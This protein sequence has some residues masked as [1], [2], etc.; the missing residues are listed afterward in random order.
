MMGL[1]E[2]LF[3]ESEYLLSI[4][5]Q[6]CAGLCPDTHDFLKFLLSGCAQQPIKN[7]SRDM[8]PE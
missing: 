7:Y 4:L 1:W 5:N 8:K 6:A 2:L 3:T